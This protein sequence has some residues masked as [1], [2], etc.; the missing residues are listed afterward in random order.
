MKMEYKLIKDCGKGFMLTREPETVTGEL[1]VSFTGAPAN[2]TAV[3][4]NGEGNSLYRL[5]KDETCAIPADF[6]KGCVRVTVAVLN[7]KEKAP[8]FTCER[9][10]A[11]PVSDGGVIV[12][13]DGL[14][15]AK[16]IIAIHGEIQGIKGVCDLLNKSVAAL[17]EKLVKLLDGY[18]FD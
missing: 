13:P 12:C 4:E 10:Y 2:A 8:K 7:G 18:D 1:I 17:G 5:L 14:D 16:E 3:F 9:I 15:V 6:L 11:K